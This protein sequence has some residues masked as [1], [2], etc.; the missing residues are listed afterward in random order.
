MVGLRFKGRL[1]GVIL[2]RHRG[3]L[4]T[5]GTQVEYIEYAPG[6]Y[7]V[8]EELFKRMEQITDPPRERFVD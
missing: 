2:Y 8:S 6:H 7:L 3:T 1:D 5:G 4:S